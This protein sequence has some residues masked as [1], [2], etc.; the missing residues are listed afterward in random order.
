MSCSA[1]GTMGLTGKDVAIQPARAGCH[2]HCP[3]ATPAKHQPPLSLPPP[4][5]DP[6]WWELLRALLRPLMWRN[7]KAEVAEEY[8]LPPRSLKVSYLAFQ[9]GEREV[10]D[11]VR[12]CEG[13]R[14]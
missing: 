13:G 7:T 2:L 14:G 8:R 3:P 6:C 12:S 4:A 5:G 1:V 11:Q 9:S 10:Y